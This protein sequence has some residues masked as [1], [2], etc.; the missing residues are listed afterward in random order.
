MGPAPYIAKFNSEGIPTLVRNE[1][2]TLRWVSAV[3][4]KDEATA[5]QIANVNGVNKSALILTRFDRT[6]DGKKLRL[7]DFAQILCKPR[8]LDY[9]GKYDASHEDVAE[10]I[11]THSAR[12]VIDLGKLFRRL[13][14]FALVGNCD[15]HLK[16]FSLL[17]T[18]S[19]LRLAPLYDVVNT[20]LFQNYDQTLALL[21]D[22]K[23][24]QLDSV[25]RPL[26]ESFGQRID[27]PKKAIDQA[28]KD[29]QTGVRRAAS[30]LIPPKGEPPDGF[31]H[32]YADI[33]RGACLRILGE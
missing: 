21:I 7:E 5:F 15:G 4:G 17:E 27:L 1:A 12:P 11:K 2:L 29:V 25:T 6:E 19:G 3:L 18:Q 32:R 26:L 9:A 14:V 20:A 16:N 33:V 30:N 10:V 22:G 8:G 28:F 31:V 23:K 24:V 13:I